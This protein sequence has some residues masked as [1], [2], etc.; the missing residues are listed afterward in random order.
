[1][2]SRQIVLK[3]EKHVVVNGW[4]ISGMAST[5]MITLQSRPWTVCVCQLAS[6]L[7][8]TRLKTRSK[9]FLVC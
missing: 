7:L 4:M 2:S 3:T 6:E 1:V 8:V 9:I 5:L